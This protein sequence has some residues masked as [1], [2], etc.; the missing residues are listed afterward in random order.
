MK[1]KYE[2]LR[3]KLSQFNEWEVKYN[4]SLHLERRLEQFLILFDIHQSYDSLKRS[5][6]HEEHLKGLI[7]TQK[8]L[9]RVDFIKRSKRIVYNSR[10]GLEYMTKP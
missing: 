6:M 8:R 1:N 3:R 9:K 4:R 10:T 5:R 2:T 7:E